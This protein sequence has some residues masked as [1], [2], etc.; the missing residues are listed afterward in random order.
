MAAN[1]GR[2]LIVIKAPSDCRWLFDVYRFRQTRATALSLRLSLL[3]E[4]SRRYSTYLVRGFA[5]RTPISIPA[6]LKVDEKLVHRR[7]ENEVPANFAA[8][9]VGESPL[10]AGISKSDHLRLRA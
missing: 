10:N 4:T 2:R 6:G 8:R 5:A 1:K 7:R 3:F 9:T